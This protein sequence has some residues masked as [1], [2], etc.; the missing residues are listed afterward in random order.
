LHGSLPYARKINQ[1]ELQLQGI[2]RFGSFNM[3]SLIQ[4]SFWIKKRGKKEKEKEKKKVHKDR[5]RCQKKRVLRA[6]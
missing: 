5:P 2:N 1:L 3:F 6:V 4:M